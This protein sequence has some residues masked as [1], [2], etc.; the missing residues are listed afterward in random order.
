MLLPLVNGIPKGKKH[1]S[2]DKILH[3][4]VEPMAVLAL[5]QPY[6]WPHWIAR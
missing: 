6:I 4:P 1:V 3:R 2:C 5:D